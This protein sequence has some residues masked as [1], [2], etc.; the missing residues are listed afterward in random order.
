MKVIEPIQSRYQNDEGRHEIKFVVKDY[1]SHL[2][3]A[4]MIENSLVFR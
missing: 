4:W 2:I 3:Y 1:Q